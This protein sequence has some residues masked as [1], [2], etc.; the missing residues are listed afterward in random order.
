[1]HSREGQG[2]IYIYIPTASSPRREAREPVLIGRDAVI[3]E[4]DGG[5]L[6]SANGG[7]CAG[8]SARGG[9]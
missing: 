6:S 9:G 4:I 2:Y 8:S 5:E 1:V 7:G 3:E